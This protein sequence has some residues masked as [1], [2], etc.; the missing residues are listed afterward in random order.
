MYASVGKCFNFYVAPV[1]MVN[2]G[3]S[4][5]VL[6]GKGNLTLNFNDIFKG[7]KFKFE[8]DTPIPQDGQFNWE[9]RTVFLGFMYSFGGGKNKARKRK[10]RDSNEASEGGFI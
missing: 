9:S 6:D 7:M 2:T 1:W 5:S 10:K 8:S 4:Y 3:A